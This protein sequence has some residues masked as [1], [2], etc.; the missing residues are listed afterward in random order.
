MLWIL[1][2]ELI[3]CHSPVTWLRLVIII[4][5]LLSTD[6]KTR[7][8]EKK[9]NQSDKYCSI[10]YCVNVDQFTKALCFNVIATTLYTLN[11]VIL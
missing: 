11:V 5:L 1:K 3:K 4:D 8:W 10:N 9:E 2:K 7:T 6:I